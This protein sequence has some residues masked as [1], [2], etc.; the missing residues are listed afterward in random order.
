MNGFSK[1]CLVIIILLFA[2]IALRPILDPQPAIA[3]TRF[4]YLVVT[5]SPASGMVQ[6]ELDKHAAEGWEFV[7]PVYSKQVPGFTLI[8][9][10]EAR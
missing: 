4:Q 1:T 6:Q 3:A 5:S 7:A 2:L 10:K 9:R 8:F